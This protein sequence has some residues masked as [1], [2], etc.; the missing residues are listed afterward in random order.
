M[1]I[2]QNEQPNGGILEIVF[3][4]NEDG[5]QLSIPKTVYDLQQAAKAEQSTPSLTDE[6]AT[7]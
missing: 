2:L 7:I 1:I 4:E 6:A 3:I 5:S